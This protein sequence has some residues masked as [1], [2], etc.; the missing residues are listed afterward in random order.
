MA[1]FPGPGFISGTEYV[2][3]ML[4]CFEDT[5]VLRTEQQGYCILRLTMGVAVSAVKGL[6]KK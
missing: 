3:R 1:V 6:K 4:S 5:W 2:F